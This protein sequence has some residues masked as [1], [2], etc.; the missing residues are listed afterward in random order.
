MKDT[1]GLTNATP[2]P[3]EPHLPMYQDKYH[4]SWSTKKRNKWISKKTAEKFITRPYF[5]FASAN[6]AVRLE[7]HKILIGGVTTLPEFPTP[8]EITEDNPANKTN[9]SSKFG[10]QVSV[11][12]GGVS[13]TVGIDS[14]GNAHGSAS[15]GSSEINGSAGPDGVNVNASSGSTHAEASANSDGADMSAGVDGHEVHINVDPES[16]KKELERKWNSARAEIEKKKTELENSFYQFFDSFDDNLPSTEFTKPL[17]ELLKRMSELIKSFFETI[18]FDANAVISQTSEIK[19]IINEFGKIIIPVDNVPGKIKGLAESILNKAIGDI[20]TILKNFFNSFMRNIT[21]I[22]GNQSKAFENGIKDIITN[23]KE[24]LTEYNIQILSKS[25]MEL[26]FEFG[27]FDVRDGVPKAYRLSPLPNMFSPASLLTPV[28]ASYIAPI[29]AVEKIAYTLF[30]GYPA[31]FDIPVKD[32][33]FF[34]DLPVDRSFHS[35][36][37]PFVNN[38]PG[39]GYFPNM[40]GIYDYLNRNTIRISLNLKQIAKEEL[41][42]D[43][44]ND[45]ELNMKDFLN[46]KVLLLNRLFS[47]ISKKSASLYSS[48]DT[49]NIEALLNTGMRI[50]KPIVNGNLTDRLTISTPVIICDERHMRSF[51]FVPSNQ[52]TNYW[53]VYNFYHPLAAKMNKEVEQGGIESLY[54][55]G[56]LPGGEIWDYKND[57]FYQSF[58]TKHFSGDIQHEDFDFTPTGVY[59]VYNWELFFYIPMLLGSGMVSDQQFE[60]AM[61]WFKFVFDP[62]ASNPKMAEINAAKKFWRFKPFHLEFSANDSGNKLPVMTIPLWL[63]HLSQQDTYTP[64]IRS[65]IETWLK[66]PFNPFVIAR[67]RPGS[68]ERFTIMRVVETLIAWGDKCFAEDTWESINEATQIYLFAREILGEKPRL[69]PAPWKTHMTYNSIKSN[70]KFDSFGNALIEIEASLPSDTEIPGASASDSCLYG[71]SGQSMLYFGIPV[72]EKLFQYWDTIEEKLFRIRHALN[73]KGKPR[74]ST[75]PDNWSNGNPINNSFDS[76]ATEFVNELN[77]ITLP[78][79]RFQGVFQKAKEFVSEVR[80]LAS[81]YMSAIEKNDSEMLSHLRATQELKMLNLTYLIKDIQIHEAELSV[82]EIT[83]RMESSKIRYEYYRTREYMN[84]S[85]K[86]KETS[87]IASSVIKLM[88]GAIMFGAAAAKAIPNK[89]ST[90][91]GGH[92]NSPNISVSGGSLAE[93]GEAFSHGYGFISSALDISSAL[94]AAKSNYDRRWEEW[95]H[96]K[97]I[98]LNDIEQNTKQI[99]IANERVRILSQELKNHKTQLEQAQE[100]E[101]YLKNKFNNKEL[102]D[103]MSKELKSLYIQSYRLAFDMAKRAELCYQYERGS[104]KTFISHENW[105]SLKSGLLSGEKLYHDM[106]RLEEAYLNE[107]LHDFD[108]VKTIS[109]TAIDPEALISLKNNKCCDF[110]IPEWIFDIEQPGHYKRRIKSVTLSIPCIV[111]PYNSV[112]CTL[113]LIR[114]SYRKNTI[115][116]SGADDWLKYTETNG[117]QGNSDSRFVYDRCKIRSIVTSTSLN[118]SGM[119]ENNRDDKYMPFEGAGVISEWYL[120]LPKVLKQFDYSTISDVILQIKYTACD[121]GREFKEFVESAT[122][123]MLKTASAGGFW[124]LFDFKY[125]F[126]NNWNQLMHNNSTTLELSQKQFPFFAS[127]YSVKINE[128]IIMVK[129]KD[130]SITELT[131]EFSDAADPLNTSTEVLLSE[132]EE[133]N[134][135]LIGSISMN[136]DTKYDVKVQN[137]TMFEELILLFRYYVE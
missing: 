127:E 92:G 112:N 13:I 56:S 71:L 37:N 63:K 55:S 66:N 73:I 9:Y 108:L 136:F 126:S 121:G 62:T 89:I 10:G 132:T 122:S 95:E 6:F 43:F 120:E 76:S 123:T 14:D 61:R 26:G 39:T 64:E 107:N 48:L 106:V 32:N 11:N 52:S 116:N 19:N 82:E 12:T 91:A 128:V 47:S 1:L 41:G 40:S 117:Q 49:K 15:C 58:I 18:S 33:Q 22:I 3:L 65:M 94:A 4:L 27:Y 35:K 100:I 57:R 38:W 17:E 5:P 111:G 99:E 54:N 72:N 125:D 130:S 135:V 8:E 34:I 85:E 24:A 134:G 115:L 59:S 131:I 16:A 96:Q 20:T 86:I 101:G 29:F 67:T 97:E 114:C 68:F 45:F 25:G 46:S 98:A 78:V 80:S 113:S 90:G 87:A 124:K 83:K 102:Y 36:V 23:I 109:L 70:E 44:D 77:V 133:I 21:D 137:A 7:G 60:N 42:I 105:D 129:P 93:A 51:I 110:K 69:I 81:A 119:F 79:Y 28:F 74:E 84:L 88:G 53:N 2:F 103:W 75:S 118:D 104:D 31:L 30:P 50:V